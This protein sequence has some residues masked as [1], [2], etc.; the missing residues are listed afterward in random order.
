MQ[1]CC[2]SRTLCVCVSVCASVFVLCELSANSSLALLTLS[3]GKTCAENGPG[4][5]HP[6]LQLEQHYIK[7]I[8]I[9]KG[10]PRGGNGVTGRPIV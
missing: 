1:V 10:L 2:V 9:M 8:Q 7:A 5:V 4:V 3:G 6:R